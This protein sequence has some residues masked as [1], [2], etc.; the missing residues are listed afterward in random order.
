VLARARA[1][2]LLILDVDGVL[3]DG[4]LYFTGEGEEM[5]RFDVRDGLGMRMLADEGVSIAIVSGRRSEAV[6]RRAESLGV[7]EVVQGVNDKLTACQ[8]LLARH[9][10]GFGECGAMGD[11]LPDLP[12]LRR[13][14]FAAAVP[15][16]PSAVLSAAHYVTGR[17]GGRGAVR[18]LCEFI[19][20]ARGGLDRALAR[21]LA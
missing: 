10:A 19:L 5:K 20:N 15:A 14:V 16:A 6:A 7:A 8:A 13:V 17:G 11:D 1:V 12:V 2:R 9:G 4:S 3:T 21:Y 18:E